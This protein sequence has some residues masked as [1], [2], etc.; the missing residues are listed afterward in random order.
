MTGVS[1]PSSMS[2]VTASSSAR[3]CRAGSGAAAARR[4]RWPPPPDPASNI[5][6][7]GPVLDRSAAPG[8]RSP[9]AA[10]DTRPLILASF[11]TMP[12]QTAP[13]LLQ[14]VLDALAGLPARV[15]LTT[16]PVAPDALRPPTRRSWRS[17]RTRRCCRRPAS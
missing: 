9:W 1:L 17:R 6:Y 8:W 5:R 14:R 12:G 16:G 3:F 7:V 2:P 10:G 15:L 11:S 4:T 13:A